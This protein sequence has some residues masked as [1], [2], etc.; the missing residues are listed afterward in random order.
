MV[1]V[2]PGDIHIAVLYHDRPD[3]KSGSQPDALAILPERGIGGTRTGT[4]LLGSDNIKVVPVDAD[5]FGYGLVYGR[6][7]S[8]EL[9]FA[10]FPY[11]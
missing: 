11:K 3:V 1:V 7:A 9:L 10:V 5:A 8:D 6:V 2:R 4:W